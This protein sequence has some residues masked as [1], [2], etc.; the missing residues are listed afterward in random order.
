[1]T[2]MVRSAQMCEE[3]HYTVECRDVAARKFEHVPM[4]NCLDVATS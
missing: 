1:M 2:N 3:V 4:E